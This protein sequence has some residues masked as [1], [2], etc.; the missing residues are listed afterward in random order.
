MS[1]GARSALLTMV[2]GS[3]L[4]PQSVGAQSPEPVA[5]TPSLR[6]VLPPTVAPLVDVYLDGVP[7]AD[8][9]DFAPVSASAYAGVPVGEHEVDVFPDGVDPLRSEPLVTAAID[10]GVDGARTL[11][12]RGDGTAMVIDD[13]ALPPATGASLRLVNLDTDAGP[14]DA[15]LGDRPLALGLSSDFPSSRFPVDAGSATLTSNSPGD[16]LSLFASEDVVLGEGTVTTAFMVPTADRAVWFLASDGASE[17]DVTPSASPAASASPT[18]STSPA[19]SATPTAR[20]TPRPTPT[21][22]PTTRPSTAS[23]ALEWRSLPVYECG[24]SIAF[25][26]DDRP[27]VTRPFGAAAARIPASARRGLALFHYPVVADYDSTTG[28]ALGPDGWTC[29]RFLLGDVD[30]SR[31]TLAIHSAGSTQPAIGSRGGRYIAYATTESSDFTASGD[32]VVTSYGVPGTTACAYFRRLRTQEPAICRGVRA[33]TGDRSVPRRSADGTTWLGFSTDRGG[34]RVLGATGIDCDTDGCL[35][36]LVEC[37]LRPEDR[38]LCRATLQ[39]M[40]DPDRVRVERASAHLACPGSVAIIRAGTG[41]RP[42]EDYSSAAV[43]RT[44]RGEHDLIV[45]SVPVA[46]TGIRYPALCG[47]PS[48]RLWY[49]VRS[50]DGARVNGWIAMPLLVVFGHD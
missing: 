15:W 35:P 11:A 18:P 14:V 22:T 2:V 30:G 48:D 44:L 6:I 13:T 29:D 46:T 17:P 20:P 33:R 49:R 1:R 4:L 9:T 39:V 12:V 28:W 19:P 10:F 41:G 24:L 23:D 47:Q 7:L 3:M 21:L 38:A 50:V 34:D 40:L 42:P 26:G 43:V 5:A 27:S 32:T 36:H 45:D 8:L 31:S 37:K 25:G 16:R